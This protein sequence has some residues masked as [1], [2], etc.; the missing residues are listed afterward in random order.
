MT[1]SHQLVTGLVDRVGHT[2]PGSSVMLVTVTRDWPPATRSTST[3]VTPTIL[4]ISSVTAET[5]CPQVIPE[6]RY[7]LTII[8]CFPTVA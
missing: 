3:P 5:Q 8:T 1:G 7:G 6:T 4:L 2:S